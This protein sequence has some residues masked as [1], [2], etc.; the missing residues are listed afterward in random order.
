M[1]KGENYSDAGL[2]ELHQ[3]WKAGYLDLLQEWMTNP[4]TSVPK[5]N[6]IT[7]RPRQDGACKLAVEAIIARYEKDLQTAGNDK[8][9]VLLA[10]VRCCQDLDQFHTFVDGNI[11]TISF[12]V[13][14]KLLLQNRLPFCV[15]LEP[16]VFDGMSSQE[17]ITAVLEGQQWFAKLCG[18]VGIVR[19]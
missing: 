11:R 6:Q 10:I 13:L 3:R 12:L 19:N 9:Q 2:Q 14:N 16:N 8:Q 5:N 7:L 18:G 17:L 1:K 15:L 4:N